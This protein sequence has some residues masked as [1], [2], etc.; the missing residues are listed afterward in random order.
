MECVDEKFIL[1][2]RKNAN[3]KKYYGKQNQTMRKKLDKFQKYELII[4][5]VDRHHAPKYWFCSAPI[6]G[7]KDMNSHDNKRKHP[8]Y[9]SEKICNG[10][11][12]KYRRHDKYGFLNKPKGMKNKW[13][14]DEYFERNDTH[15]VLGPEDDCQYHFKCNCK[16]LIDQQTLH[17]STEQSE[18]SETNYTRESDIVKHCNN[19]LIDHFM[20]YLPEIFDQSNNTQTTE[21]TDMIS[22]DNQSPKASEPIPI[23]LGEGEILL[24]WDTEMIDYTRNFITT[25]YVDGTITFKYI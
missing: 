24:S 19:L 9:V 14:Y 25:Y 15:R 20:V 11:H 4:L 13:K 8:Q 1:S 3:R 16:E 6:I 18:F 22:M 17:Q 21:S 23:K 7:V 5:K 2:D 12:D 10:R